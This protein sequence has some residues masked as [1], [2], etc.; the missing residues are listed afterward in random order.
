MNR[1]ARIERQPAVDAQHLAVDE[2]G[3]GA[4]EEGHGVGD[5]VGLGVA[6]EART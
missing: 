6:V 4:A 2:A 3:R 1:S 5:F